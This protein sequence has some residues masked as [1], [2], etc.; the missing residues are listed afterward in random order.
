MTDLEKL[1]LHNL[2]RNEP[3]A[4]KVTPFLKREYFHDRS[5]RF[6]FETIHDFIIKYNNL[7][8]KEALHII[9]DKNKTIT[10]DELK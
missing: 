5:I 8:T 2:L 9:L 7:P 4:R 6:V 1:I 3:Y 10:Q